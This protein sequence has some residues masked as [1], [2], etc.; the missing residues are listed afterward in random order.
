MDLSKAFDYIP[1]KFLKAKV[2]VYGYSENALV[3]FSYLKRQKQSVQIKN[4]Y[5][6]F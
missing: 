2:D 3:F 5:S 4:T 1:R 6:I